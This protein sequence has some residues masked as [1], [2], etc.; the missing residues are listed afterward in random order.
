MGELSI[1]ELGERLAMETAAMRSRMEVVLSRLRG[2]RP[3]AGAELRG[4]K[5]D[6]GV[7]GQ[8]VTA[9][10]NTQAVGGMLDEL[11]SIVGSGKAL[12]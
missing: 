10:D 4:T 2:A 7:Q 8:L 6:M 5:P 1:T 3:A 12:R 9:H 11:D